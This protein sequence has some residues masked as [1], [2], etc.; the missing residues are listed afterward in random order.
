MSNAKWASVPINKQ[1]FMSIGKNEK[2]WE[3]YLI[4][5]NQDGSTIYVR[6]QV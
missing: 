5:K 1:E 2:D 6:R 3:Q 4:K